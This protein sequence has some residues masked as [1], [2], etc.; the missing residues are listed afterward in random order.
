MK[1]TKDRNQFSLFITYKDKGILVDCG[2]GTQRQLKIAG[3]SLTKISK[4]LITHWH[5]DHVLGIPGLLQTMSASDYNG[6]LEIY[7]PIGTKKKL[8]YVFKAFEFDNKIHIKIYEVGEGVNYEDGSLIIEAYP[9]RHSVN[10]VA[11]SL[12]EKDK[13]K[14][15]PIKVNSLS[16]PGYL[17]GKL[18]EGKV[19]THRSKEILPENVGSLKKGQKIGI[20][21]DTLANENCYNV[22]KDCDILV[23]EAVYSSELDD[24]A[25]RYMHLTAKDAALIANKSNSKKLVLAH[26]ST[27]Y[28]NTHDI[29]KE[30]RD[31]FDNVLSAE[32]FMEIRS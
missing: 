11:Y 32:D 17:V 28:K 14:I 31:Y 29:E 10:C 2:E 4:I 3:I 15:D 19:V 5:G 7:G 21:L 22:A 6:K 18:Q 30:A 26:F 8:S 24:K 13:W 23:C 20:I 27:R 25:K 1:P 9:M 16:I 12:K